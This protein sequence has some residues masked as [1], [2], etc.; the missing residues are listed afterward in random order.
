MYRVIGKWSSYRSIR[1][2]MSTHVLNLELQLVLC[3][4]VGALKTGVNIVLQW[5]GFRIFNYLEGKM[6]QEVCSAIGG[7][8]LSTATSI[9]PHANGRSLSPWRVLSSDL[10]VVSKQSPKNTSSTE[11]SCS[12]SSRWRGWSIAWW[13]QRRK[14]ESRSLWR[15]ARPSKPRGSAG[16]C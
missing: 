7:I 3:P 2:E 10:P 8:G 16:H 5:L 14:W 12:P 13:Q 4:P 6:F 9:N 1:I 15:A 11:R